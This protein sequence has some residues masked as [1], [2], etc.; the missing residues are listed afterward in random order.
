MKE[1]LKFIATLFLLVGLLGFA[2]CSTLFLFFAMSLGNIAAAAIIVAVGVLLSL[3][4][5]LYYKEE[6]EGED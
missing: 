2:L 6:I 3:N 1:I 5:Y 4:L